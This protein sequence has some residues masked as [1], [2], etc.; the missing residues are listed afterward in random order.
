[1]AHYPHHLSPGGF[2]ALTWAGFGAAA[3][4]V[5]CRAWI[6]LRILDRFGWPDLWIALAFCTLLASAIV[7]TTATPLLYDRACHDDN[8]SRE[9]PGQTRQRHE[10]AKYFIAL[11]FLFLTTLWAVKAAFLALFNPLFDGMRGMKRWWMG[12]TVFT[13]LL[14][15]SC[16][17][18]PVVVSIAARR[19]PS[20]HR[21]IAAHVESE[22][23]LEDLG[24]LT[25]NFADAIILFAAAADIVSDLMSKL[26]S[27]TTAH[28]L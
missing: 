13:G 17:L 26:P 21:N 19:K 28:F 3:F 22:C 5:L 6:R 25:A 27:H 11:T 15:L 16:L 14:F 9:A 2:V 8:P 12:V 20:E 7:L 23:E 24:M 1:M 10:F 18:P 4:F